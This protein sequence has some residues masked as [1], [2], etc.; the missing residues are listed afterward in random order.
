MLSWLTVVNIPPSVREIPYGCFVDCRL[1]ELI[2]PNVAKIDD[3][4]IYNNENLTR[5]EIGT[6]L[7]EMS[8][9][10]I[11]NNTQLMPLVIPTTVRTLPVKQDEDQYRVVT[12]AGIRD[13]PC[14]MM[15]GFIYRV[16]LDWI[17]PPLILEKRTKNVWLFCYNYK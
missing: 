5:L 13:A 9:V 4:G 2:L 14:G 7:R 16:T 6:E 3:F 12:L 1:K 15:G 8:E 17:Q 11:A 10:A